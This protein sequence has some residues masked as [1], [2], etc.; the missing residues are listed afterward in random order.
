MSN[1]N[2]FV[3]VGRITRPH[4][5]RGEVCA[6]YYA[7][8]LQYLDNGQAFLKTEKSVPKPL[9]IS[10]RKMQ[11]T[12]LIFKI[13]GVDTRTDAEFLRNYDIV[14]D[15]NSLVYDA[16]PT[17]NSAKQNKIK[18]KE[19]YDTNNPLNAA[20]RQENPSDSSTSHTLYTD[21]DDDYDDDYEG[22]APFL[23][24]ILGAKAILVVAQSTE[25]SQAQ[26]PSDKQS[27]QESGTAS[28]HQFIS[29][30]ENLEEEVGTIEEISFPA[31]Q[32][33]WTIINAKG[34]EILFP[35]VSEF[36]DH[37]DLDNNKIYINPPEG[38]LEIYLSEVPE[39]EKEPKEM[40]RRQNA[41]KN[42]ALC[43]EG[44]KQPK[45]PKTHQ[46]KD[47]S[48]TQNLNQEKGQGTKKNLNQDKNKETDASKV[49]GKNKA[50]GANEKP[51]PSRK[52]KKKKF[53]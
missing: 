27:P 14:I 1:D 2:S 29:T 23:H 8:S 9:L 21:D 7:E 4:G 18:S 47:K 3:T 11:G 40:K 34:Q 13:K 16:A 24:H 10:S 26:N 19:D 51:I 53:R 35:A 33:L 42:K 49:A 31:G 30:P 12:T 41:H 17:K 46:D 28:V 6:Q 36:I 32:E 43:G 5:I 37:Y 38:L 22:D 44:K 39:P 45:A 50:D 20:H 15:E 52:N 25:S 48:A